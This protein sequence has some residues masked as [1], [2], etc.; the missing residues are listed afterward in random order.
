MHALAW[1]LLGSQH[2]A[3]DVT[4]QTFLGLLEHLSAFREESSVATWV[5]RMATNHALKLLRQAAAA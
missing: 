4:Q 3:E 2:D 1:R 5:L